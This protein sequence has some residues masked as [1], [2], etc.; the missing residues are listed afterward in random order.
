MRHKLVHSQKI[1][2]GLATE[3][4]DLIAKHSQSVSLLSQEST[5]NVVQSMEYNQQSN[6]F[7]RA[8]DAINAAAK[9]ENLDA[10]TL[11]YVNLTLQCVHCHKYVR[12]LG[13]GGE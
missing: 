12:N 4:F 11:G 13:T 1:L 10:A 8:A 7:R 5:W 3:D 9:K 2:E 6:E